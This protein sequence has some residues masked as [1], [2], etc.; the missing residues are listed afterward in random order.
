MG[1]LK[2]EDSPMQ[3]GTAVQ[4]NIQSFGQTNLPNFES[5]I[6]CLT[7]I[8]QI[9]GHMILPPQNKTTKYEHI[10]PQLVAIEENP[11]I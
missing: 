9:E 5:S 10:I 3:T 6:H 8:G 4:Q 11:Q 1:I 7:I 2:N